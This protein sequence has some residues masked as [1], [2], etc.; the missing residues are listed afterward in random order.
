MINHNAQIIYGKQRDDERLNSNYRDFKKNNAITNKDIPN[1]NRIFGIG[2][3]QQNTIK[4]IYNI[5][6]CNTLKSI[7][8]DNYGK[9]DHSIKNIKNN[10][11]SDEIAYENMINLKE[12]SIDFRTLCNLR[13]GRLEDVLS[14]RYE[15]NTSIERGQRFLLQHIYSKVDLVIMY[16]D[17][18]GSTTMSMTLPTGKV[19]T[20]LKAFS[21]ELS[22]VI[23]NYGGFVLKYV[24]D[25]I[26]S[27]FPSGFN[28]YLIC[29]RAYRCAK[30]MI[31]G[32]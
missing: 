30:S 8:N 16:A 1:I 13:Q 10:E 14:K 32:T 17:M 4:L 24:G 28:K 19:V 29:D 27:F 9:S 6:V 12:N 21:H 20:I 2:S 7:N 18:V 25:A 23:E 31:S 26:I 3:K 11:F 15:Y 22:S 5:I